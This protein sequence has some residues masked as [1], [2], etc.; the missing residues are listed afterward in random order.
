MPRPKHYG[1]P[2][3]MAARVWPGPHTRGRLRSPGNG[4]AAKEDFRESQ[5]Y[6][7]QAH[8]V[9]RGGFPAVLTPGQYTHHPR[10]PH[11]IATL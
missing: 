1:G 6:N 9:L 4:A 3:S 8:E 11:L 10:C 2:G 5:T 7:L